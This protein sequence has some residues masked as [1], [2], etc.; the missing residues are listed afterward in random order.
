M[1][2]QTPRLTR[3]QRVAALVLAA[4]A[5][6]F[7]TLDL[8][9]SSLTSAHD[10]ARGLL[11]SLYRGTDSV[12]GPVRRFVQG[13]PHA[14][15]NQA[16]VQALQH[17]NAQLRKQLA[18]AGSDRRTVAELD[19][20][21]LAAS[22]GHYP[23]LPA[24]V[25]AI[26]PAEGFDWTVTLDVGSSSG[27]RV[28]QSVTDGNGL[29]GRVLHADSA[30]SVVLLAVDPGSGAGGRDERTGAL[31]VATGIGL[32]GFRFR[33]LDPHASVQAGDELRTGPSRASSFVA[34]L[35]IGT[36]ESVRTA[37]DGTTIATVR[38]SADPDSLDLVGVVLNHTR[39]NA[40]RAALQPA[41]G[42]GR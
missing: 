9:G 12:L 17:E 40:V 35:A 23:V 7:V 3:R 19:K 41:A 16:R 15:S 10:G 25:I 26:S 38:P 33:P 24:R 39:S 8:A 28:G 13:V 42:G 22:T 5:V 18:D 20:L 1:K 29:V 36:V 32:G 30:T 34:G 11:G 27:V 37:D 21:Q 14:A 2:R 31:G 6:C 4:V